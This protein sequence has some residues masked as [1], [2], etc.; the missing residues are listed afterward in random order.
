MKTLWKPHEGQQTYALSINEDTFIDKTDYIWQ[1]NVG[2]PPRPGLE[3]MFMKKR[4]DLLVSKVVG[5]EVT[6][7]QGYFIR[8]L[9]KNFNINSISNLPKNIWQTTSASPGYSRK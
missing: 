2:F 4:K 9:N 3:I 5:D 1:L 6:D 8:E 7:G